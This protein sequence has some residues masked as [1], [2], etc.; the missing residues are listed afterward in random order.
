MRSQDEHLHLREPVEDP[1]GRFDPA[2]HRHPDVHQDDIRHELAGEVDRFGAVLRAPDDL[3]ARIGLEERR[4]S[5]AEERIVVDDENVDSHA[6]EE[7]RRG[8]NL[9]RFTRSSESI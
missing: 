2:H 3:D 7:A 6:R 5:L 8:G 4:Y 9:P 1:L